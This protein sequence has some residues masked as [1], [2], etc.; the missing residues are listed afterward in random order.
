MATASTASRSP[1]SLTVPRS[2]LAITPAAGSKP[3]HRGLTYWMS[4]VLEELG[5]LHTSPDPDTV[6]DLRVA[7]RRCRSL[8][9]AIQ[10]VDPDPAWH[11]M[12]KVGRKLFRSLGSLR[13]A[14]VMEEWIK[15]LGGENDPLRSQ[16]LASLE[17]EEKQLS[18][19]A[20]R[21]AVKFDKK[22]WS[23]LERHL[24]QRARLVPVGGLVAE[25]LALERFEE[26]KE[27]HN[28]A[29]RSEKP[30]TWH[31]LRIGLKRFRYALEGLLPDHYAA[32]VDNLKR[33]QDLLG[34]VHD[35][36][37][38]SQMVKDAATSEAPEISESAKAWREKISRE[39][40]E[41]I[42]TYRQLTLGKTS[43]WHDWRHNLPHGQ[44]LEAA[45][46]ARLRA[47]ARAA[48]AHSRRNAQIARLAI[49]LF[50]LL[51]RANAAPLFHDPALRRMME[52]AAKLHSIP[53]AGGRRLSPKTLRKFL[54]GL[55]V[56]PN[57]STEEWDLMAWAVRFHRGPEPKLKN[58]FAKLS[59]E[60][61]TAV[62]ALAGVLRLARGLRKTGIERTVGLRTEK[63]P[64]AIVLRVPALTDT[65]E[66]AARLA[67]AKHLLES[68]L[69]K[70]L[71]LKT[72]P[73]PDHAARP[74]EPV[75]EPALVASA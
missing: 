39:R 14:H 26:A 70:S 21:V 20:V 60:Q 9:A 19:S 63:S 66:T 34:D 3:D 12:R 15:K 53:A 73:I 41:R 43:L 62:R 16:R 61:Q 35:L 7:I 17:R 47:T 46:A 68:V 58:G 38:L 30:K 55:T 74:S 27:L 8:A 59:D 48:D 25:C 65:E 18:E 31:A 42:E 75:S 32:W 56:P 4:R 37:V 52:A 45:A 69:E 29:L 50:D 1:L 49:R 72:V 40:H 5:T 13:D 64:E 6:H 36:D 11:K 57:W 44:R 71:I 2:P 23:R 28:R 24:R 51:G 54:L 22:E 10:E 67:A 33:L